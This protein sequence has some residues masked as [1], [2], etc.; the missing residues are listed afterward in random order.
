MYGLRHF[1]T[2]TPV[3]LQRVEIFLDFCVA[4]SVVTNGGLYRGITMVGSAS[5]SLKNL[6]S[7]LSKSTA[8]V[9]HPNSPI[10]SLSTR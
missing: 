4:M 3:R 6:L 1:E 8:N 10:L 7:I 5:G 9:G 2:E